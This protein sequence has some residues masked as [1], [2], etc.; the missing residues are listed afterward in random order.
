MRLGAVSLVLL[1]AAVAALLWVGLAAAAPPP[2]PTPPQKPTPKP[3]PSTLAFTL[4]PSKLSFTAEVGSFD[5]Q[6]VTLK[7]RKNT[8][9]VID[10]LTTFSDPNFWDTQAGTCWQW[11][12]S[13]GYE[14][15]A[16][17]TCTIQV[18]FSPKAAGTSSG[19]MAVYQCETWEVTDAGQ[20]TCS[21]T[22]FSQK[23]SLS[24]SAVAPEVALTITAIVFGAPGTPQ[25]NTDHPYTVTVLNSGTAT[26]DISS[27]GI[28]G[29][30]DPTAGTWPGEVGACGVTMTGT[31]A[32]GATKDVPVG[33]SQQP[34]SGYYLVVKV[35]AGDN[36]A[37]S[38]EGNNI[39]SIVVP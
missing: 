14:I 18:G 15:P 39:H 8:P 1:M 21:S 3:N 20:I 16:K 28:Q 30:Y 7:N 13:L 6:M 9:L 35:D 19:S 10:P 17:A 25:A 4:S 29:Y 33:C 2:L 38:Q 26:A 23:I 31:L 37:E 32:P 27:V 24:G 5:Y 22:G 12:E 11:Y 34:P 36:L